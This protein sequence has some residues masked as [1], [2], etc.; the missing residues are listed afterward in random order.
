MNI[1]PNILNT[2]NV[3]IVFDPIG[4]CEDVERSSTKVESFESIEK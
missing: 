2:E 1:I 4:N 3:D